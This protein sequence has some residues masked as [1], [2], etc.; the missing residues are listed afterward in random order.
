[1]SEWK[2]SYGSYDDHMKSHEGHMKVLSD[3]EK[4]RL[5]LLKLDRSLDE[6]MRMEQLKMQ[7]LNLGIC[8]YRDFGRDQGKWPEWIRAKAAE[9]GIE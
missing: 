7:K 5:R 9:L 4:E 6:D 3:V 2:D 8:V 1:M